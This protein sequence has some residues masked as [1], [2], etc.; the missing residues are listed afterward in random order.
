MD[1]KDADFDVLTNYDPNNQR[2]IKKHLDLLVVIK[3]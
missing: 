3:D 2:K 1:I